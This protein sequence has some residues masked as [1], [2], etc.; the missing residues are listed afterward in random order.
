MNEEILDSR[1]ERVI[2][3]V[4]SKKAEMELWDKQYNEAQ[5]H[6]AVVAR[7]KRTF[8]ISVAASIVLLGG[9]G[10]SLYVNRGGNGTTDIQLSMPVYRGGSADIS[11]IYAMMDSRKYDEALLA[12]ETTMADTAIDPSFTPERKEYLREVNRNQQ[13]EL[14]WLKIY[15][16]VESGK[17]D[18]AI[19]LL[20]SYVEEKGQHQPEAK[21]LLKSLE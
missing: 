7:R 14:T 21:K 3:S 8:L 15:V 5:L 20:Q 12:I 9:I 16:L 18:E 6:R 19:K 1:I 2:G 13:Y 17:K 4:A 11:E 10:V